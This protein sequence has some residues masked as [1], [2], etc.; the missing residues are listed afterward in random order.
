M[1]F[2]AQLVRL[3]VDTSSG[4]FSLEGKLIKPAGG[5]LS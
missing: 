1:F 4:I 2:Y 5:L 3:I